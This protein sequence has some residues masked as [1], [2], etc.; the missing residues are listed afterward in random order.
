MPLSIH[1]LTRLK[2]KIIMMP[3]LITSIG[4]RMPGREQDFINKNGPT[5][6]GEQ[7]SVINQIAD[8]YLG[9]YLIGEIPDEDELGT[10]LVQE[11][12]RRQQVANRWHPAANKR[13]R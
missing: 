5:S 10:R 2:V 7:Q 9:K 1:V 13:S 12:E 11:I 8:D 3:T 4:V 6:K